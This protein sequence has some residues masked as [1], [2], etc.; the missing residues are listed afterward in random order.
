LRLKTGTPPRV[1]TDS[2]DFGK[3]E[4]ELG[5]EGKL[6]FSDE[7]PD[8]ELVPFEKQVPCYLSYTTEE[9]HRLIR[10][11]L[12]L[13]SM[14]SGVI[15]G[16]GPRYCPSIETKIVRF[17]DKEHH[18]IFLEP[19]SMHIPET[20][21][22]GFSTSMPREI[23]ERMIKSLPGLEHARIARYAY[24]IEYDAV[25]PLELNPSLET[26]KVKGLYF[27]GQVNGTSGY[28]EAACQ[29]LMAG[30]NA[31]LALAGRPPLILR[32]DEAYIGVLIDDLVTK[33]ITDP[34]RMLTSRAEYRLLLRHDNA[35]VRLMKKGHEVGLISDERYER[36]T[37]KRDAI[38]TEKEHL[39]KVRISPKEEVNRYLDSI[40]SPRLLDSVT[41]YDLMKRPEI[42]YQDV[43]RMMGEEPKFNEDVS[44]Q[45]TIETKYQGY[46]SKAY[47]EAGR[48]LKFEDW[49]IPESIN[50]HDIVNLASEAR[51]KLD[52]VRPL[53]ISQASRISGVNPSD[54]AILLVYLESRKS[55]EL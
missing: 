29:G 36:F 3:T 23:Q 5:T 49:K 50:Y 9:T 21:I 6:K 51:E 27:A 45:I 14:Y 42:R 18:Q 39:T 54:I 13:S 15:E 2:I 40:N 10:E 19:E 31:S 25:D 53:T 7:T 37:K 46:I 32:R 55:H 30:I 41:A 26:K 28:E 24:A 4:L 17:A 16:I 43:V 22:Q 38:E 1:Y 35:D 47:K 20:Y 33:G 48:M 12:G 34:Y 11:N 52:K 44:N 8:E